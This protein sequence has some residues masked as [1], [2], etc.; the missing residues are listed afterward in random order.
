MKKTIVILSLI[1]M[2]A[3]LLV[4]FTPKPPQFQTLHGILQWSKNNLICGYPDYVNLPVMDKYYIAGKGF[5]TTGQF[6]GCTLDAH[7]T[8]SIIEGCYIFTVADYH[9]SCPATPNNFPG[10]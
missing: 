2:V 4:A 5:P 10:Q 7:G 6:K 8:V 9:I 1:V 3:S